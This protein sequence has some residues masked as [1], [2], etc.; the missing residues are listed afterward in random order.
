[1]RQ[2]TVA[3][4]KAT[5][6]RLLVAGED[7]LSLRAI[8]RAMGITAPAIYRYFPSYDALINVLVASLYDELVEVMA[9]ARDAADPDDVAAQLAASARAFR[10]WAL[11]HPRE[12]GAIFANPVQQPHPHPH[13][14]AELADPCVQAGHRFGGFF[15]ALFVR[16]W[17]ER[18]FPTPTPSDIDPAIRAQLEQAR[19]YVVPQLPV[20]AVWVFVRQWARLYG[21]VT[22]EVFGHLRWAMADTDAFFAAMLRESLAELGQPAPD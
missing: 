6:R 20:E 2:A 15:G 1:M 19:A 9:Q 14:E 8:A 17:T 13:S 22:M 12:F 18:G 3:E 16:L 11:E 5:A 21:A 4:I 7:A 10:A